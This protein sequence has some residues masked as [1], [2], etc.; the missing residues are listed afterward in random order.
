MLSWRPSA[1]SIEDADIKERI[2]ELHKQAGGR[3]G[4]RPIYHHLQEEAFDCGRDR[5]LRLMKELGIV[6]RQKKGFKPLATNS[7]MTSIIVPTD[8]VILGHRLAAIRS[9][10]RI[11]LI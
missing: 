7:S 1:R 2:A 4:H 3:Y 5:T 11:R 8:S 9:G 10:W 6:G